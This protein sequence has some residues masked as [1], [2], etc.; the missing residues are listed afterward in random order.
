[1]IFFFFLLVERTT[2]VLPALLSADDYE[3]GNYKKLS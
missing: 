3:H 2:M 1:M